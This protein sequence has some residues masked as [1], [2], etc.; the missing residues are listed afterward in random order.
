MLADFVKVRELIDTFTADGKLSYKESFVVALRMAQ[1]LG[2]AV[3]QLSDPS[4]LESLI[5]ECEEAYDEHIAPL[6]ISGVPNWIEN[7][8]VDP[9]IK[10]QIRPALTMMAEML[11][12]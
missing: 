8:F 9:T 2:N 11:W 4:Q 7:R 10:S 1:A 3:D 6:D 5:L 12:G